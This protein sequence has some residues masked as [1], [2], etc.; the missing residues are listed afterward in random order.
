MKWMRLIRNQN[1]M[2]I[3]DT[4]GAELDAFAERRSMEKDANPNDLFVR[5][6]PPMTLG[7]GFS[8]WFNQVA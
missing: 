2:A 6:L 3:E 1:G 7:K 4:D 8:A 5:V